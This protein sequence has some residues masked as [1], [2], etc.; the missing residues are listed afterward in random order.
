[1][2]QIACILK[3]TAICLFTYLKQFLPFLFDLKWLSDSVEIVNFDRM[4]KN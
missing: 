2:A 4:F 3:Q 1:M